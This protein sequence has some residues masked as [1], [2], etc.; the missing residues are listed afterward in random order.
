MTVFAAVVHGGFF[1]GEPEQD[2]GQEQRSFEVQLVDFTPAA[3]PEAGNEQPVWQGGEKEQTQRQGAAVGGSRPAVGAFPAASP[4]SAAPAAVGAGETIAAMGDSQSG[5]LETGGS[6]GAAVSGG[7]GAGNGAPAAKSTPPGISKSAAVIEGPAPEY[8]ADART[9]R[10]EGRVTVKMLVSESGAVT[11]AFVAGSSGFSSL[12][13][14]AVRC[15]RYWR[16]SPKYVDG[17]PV[18]A[19]V[20]K[21]VVFHLE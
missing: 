7:G 11:E 14:A 5:V 21:P 8:P 19:W 16:F 18:A 2:G 20:V 15:V 13:S 10:W 6:W 4:A 9:N 12:D 3:R 17:Q 1:S